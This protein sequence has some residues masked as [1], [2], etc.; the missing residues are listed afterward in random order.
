MEAEKEVAS[1][2]HLIYPST[3]ERLFEKDQSVFSR[4]CDTHAAP[5]Y[6]VHNFQL[7]VDSHDHTILFHLRASESRQRPADSQL[8]AASALPLHHL[9]EGINYIVR[10]QHDFDFY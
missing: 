9:S 4:V 3:L 8:C 6:S 1:I 5:Y 7:Y 10:M 2:D